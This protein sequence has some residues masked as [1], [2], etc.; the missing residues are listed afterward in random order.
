[1]KI[2]LVILGVAIL[3]GA[4]FL[5][6]RRYTF[7]RKIDNSI[8]QLL[9]A[10]ET[11]QRQVFTHAHLEGLPAPVQRYFYTVL[12]EGQEYIRLARMKQ[13]GQF[14]LGEEKENWKPFTAEEY[15]TAHPFGFVWIARISAA[16]LLAVTVRDRYFRGAGSMLAKF[17]STI[18]IIDQADQ[19]ELNAGALVRCLTESV[20]LPTALLPG[21]NLRWE[22]IDD[23]SARVVFSD[24]G[25]QAVAVFH[26]NSRGE[27]FKI[28]VPDR[29]REVKGQYVITPWTIY[30]GE[31]QEFQGV[32]IPTRA[33]VE[34]NLP[35][36]A[37]KYFKGAVTEIDFNLPER[38]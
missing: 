17:A 12:K 6:V 25:I 5:A 33:E 9:D 14:N 34:W 13:T 4:L 2:I 21:E 37:L 30:L 35:Q 29:Y 27:V 32:K 36:G 38:Y 24:E 22:A 26:F 7:S 3:A 19:P 10:A 23:S 20:W 31:Y 1:M 11:G 15:F 28:T 8:S 18:T 16:P